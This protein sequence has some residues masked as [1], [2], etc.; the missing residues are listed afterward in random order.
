MIPSRKPVSTSYLR[1]AE[2]AA[3]NPQLAFTSL[4]Q[5]L[6]ES[7]LHEAW[8]RTRK[9]GAPGVDGTTMQAYGEMLADRAPSLIAEAKSGRYKAPPVRRVYL[10]KPGSSEQRPIGI[11][12]VEDR[13]LQRA[14][15]GILEPIYEQ[16][17]LDCSYGFRPGRSAHQALAAVRQSCMAMGTCWVLDLDIR[18]YFDTIDHRHLRSI[19]D[20]RVRDGVIRRLIDKWLKAGVL[21]DNTLTRSTEG[22]PQGGVISPLLANVYLHH[23]LDLWVEY[24]VKPRLRGRVELIRYADDSVLVFQH[25][26]DARRVM[27]VI[28]KRFERYG[29]TLHPDKTRLQRFGPDTGDGRPRDAH[30]DKPRSFDFL[31]FTLH[32]ARSTYG[33]WYVGAKTASSRFTRALRKIHEWCRDNR[34]LPMAEQHKGLAS[35]LRGHYAYYGVRGNS[36]RLN[37]FLYEVGNRWRYWLN[38]RGRDRRGRHAGMPWP[39][40]RAYLRLHPLP[41]GRIVATC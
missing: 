20:Q 23:V 19:L 7:S 35:R 25:E 5:Y 2:L 10:P 33:K 41:Y 4:N 22:S 29:L 36:R 8:G 32:W 6:D 1:I 31:G 11:P 9:Q 38:R 15:L 13:V 37:D 21:E 16:D 18:R 28:G 27:A 39:R 12:T 40:F 30:E 3:S 17:F 26:S 14:V 24:T 34:H